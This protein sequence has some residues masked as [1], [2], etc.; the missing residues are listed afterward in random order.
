MA[1]EVNKYVTSCTV[2]QIIKPSQ[3][4]PAGLMVPIRPQKSWEYVGVDFVGL[5][6]H[7][8]SGNAYILVFVDIF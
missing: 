3:R 8:P 6:L 1:S 7:T 2:C 4:K 5:L